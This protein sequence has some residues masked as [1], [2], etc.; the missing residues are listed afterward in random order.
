MYF[1]PKLLPLH[2]TVIF[3]HELFSGFSV[4]LP[5]LDLWQWKQ[6]IDRD[7]CSWPHLQG[8]WS[9]GVVDF[10]ALQGK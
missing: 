10:T 1:K 3:T 8:G 2:I 5:G 4:C 6:V 9:R 7:Q